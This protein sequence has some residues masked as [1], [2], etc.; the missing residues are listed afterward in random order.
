M[1]KKSSYISTSDAA[2]RNSLVLYLNITDSKDTV[3]KV[4]ERQS[5]RKLLS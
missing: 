1:S 4:C 5:R 3:K 2:E